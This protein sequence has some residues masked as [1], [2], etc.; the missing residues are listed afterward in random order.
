MDELSEISDLAESIYAKATT[1]NKPE[2]HLISNAA[3]L[4]NWV[5]YQAKFPDDQESKDAIATLRKA[6]AL[7]PSES[8]W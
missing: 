7:P 1:L 5:C 6:L 2:R 8:C 4:I 3:R